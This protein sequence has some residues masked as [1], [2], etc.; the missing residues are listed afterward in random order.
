LKY[1]NR[2]VTLY[3]A[4]PLGTCEKKYRELETC[5]KLLSAEKIPDLGCDLF[6]SHTKS[7]ACT[8]GATIPSYKGRSKGG[9]RGALDRPPKN[10]CMDIN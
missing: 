10:L 2:T 7:R 3:L 6:P 1:S 8:E 5:I 9:S 4:I